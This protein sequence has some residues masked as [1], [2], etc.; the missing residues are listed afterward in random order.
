VGCADGIPVRSDRIVPN[1][2]I[3]SVKTP[4]LAYL[5][6]IIAELFGRLGEKLLSLQ[7]RKLKFR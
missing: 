6:K 7:H 4:I 5:D 3:I 2:I 1:F